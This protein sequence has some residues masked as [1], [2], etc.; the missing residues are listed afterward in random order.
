MGVCL[1]SNSCIHPTVV[2]VLIRQMIL[3]Q[4]WL[5]HACK[6]NLRVDGVGM[7]LPGDNRRLSA[8][9][10]QA[11]RFQ[12]SDYVRIMHEADWASM[13][14]KPGGAPDAAS[15]SWS[16]QLMDFFNGIRGPKVAVVQPKAYT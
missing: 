3:K 2:N 14:P 10:L 4:R 13:G 5:I 9:I 7:I 8:S 11:P 16:V 15:S 6:R 1:S 12:S